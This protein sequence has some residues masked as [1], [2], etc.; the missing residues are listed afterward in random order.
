MNTLWLITLRNIKIY[1]K[2]KA[3]IFFSLLSPVII[4]VLYLLFIGKLQTDGLTQALA[5]IGVTGAEAE[6]K[7]FC[8]SWMIT[9]VM[10]CACITVALCASGV[11]V[12]DRSRGIL[13][14]VMASPLPGWK[15]TA[16]YI[17]AVALIASAVSL[18]V[19]A[20]CFVYLAALGS[21]YLSVSDVFGCVGVTLLSVLSSTAV[22]SLIVSFVR[23]EGAFSGVNIIIGTVVGFL[24]GAYM[25][26]STFPKAVQTVTLFIPGSYSAGLFRQFFMGGALERLSGAVPAAFVEEL[27]K[28][29]SMTYDFFGMEI[30]GAGM[31]WILAGSVL[32]FAGANLAVMAVKKRKKY[33]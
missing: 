26:I 10:A 6:V 21:W 19:L 13:A 28:Q 4:L 5:E 22:V 30:T 24:I 8:D 31:A 14:D 18:V 17:L 7:G 25:P 27:A 32:L 23:T 11:A 20:I 15:F 29:Y 9:G 16:G 1:L 12:T 33:E 2:D 3:N